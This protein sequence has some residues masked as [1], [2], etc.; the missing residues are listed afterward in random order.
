MP[1]LCAR[2]F[3]NPKQR[4]LA[5]LGWLDYL[6]STAPWIIACAAAMMLHIHRCSAV[7]H[8][9]LR[10]LSLASQTILD[11]NCIP[12]LPMPRMFAAARQEEWAGWNL[13]MQNC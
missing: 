3:N 1:R 12:I 13:V 4:V 6:L 10:L 11:E 2:M 8:D 5:V 7:T 9:A